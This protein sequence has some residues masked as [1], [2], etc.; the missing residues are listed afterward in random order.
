M[1]GSAF[2]QTLMLLEGRMVRCYRRRIPAER[3]AAYRREALFS[4][5]G[6]A[7]MEIVKKTSPEL[8]LT[9]KLLRSGIVLLLARSFIT[10]GVS[11]LVRD[12]QLNADT[13]TA[14]AVIAS[15][16]AG[17]PES[18][19]T[20]LA[21]SN[22]A[23]ML[24]SYAAERAG[25]PPLVTYLASAREKISRAG[26][27]SLLCVEDNKDIKTRNKRQRSVEYGSKDEKLSVVRADFRADDGV[28]ASVPR[29]HGQAA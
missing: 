18:S 25:A 4:L 5:A 24:T 16:L 17:K 21:L 3:L 28:A 22:G 10:N 12:R 27:K 19:L 14:T 13:L 1:T 29:L 7:A 26:R 9:T 6:F 2:G 8:F 11:G 15:V 20:L 23:E